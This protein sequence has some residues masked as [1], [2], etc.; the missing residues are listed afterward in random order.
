ML[1][2]ISAGIMWALET[3]ILGIALGRDFIVSSPESAALAPLVCTFF[4]DAFS[5][6]FLWIYVIVKGEVKNALK[7]FKMSDF[8]WL[9]VAS[10]VGGPIGM[11]GYV[12]A[13]NFMGA[14]VGAIASA[15]YPAIGSVLAFFFLKQ[16]LK[17]YQ[18][19]F[20]VLTLLGVFGI[21]YSP[22]IDISNFGM[23]LLGAFMCAF[24]W[25][26]EGVILSKCMQNDSVESDYALL[27]RQ[28][29]SGAV[30]GLVILP[31]FRG[32]GFTAQ[33]F[34]KGNISVLAVIALAAFC[35]TVS[36]LLYYKTIAK[37]G[38]AKAMALN[39]TYT[40]WATLFSVIILKDFRLLNPT[41]LGCGAVIVICGILSASDLS[42]LSK[43]KKENGR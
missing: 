33:F 10:A 13:V 17:G 18:W 43:T 20:L 4:H 41:T 5:A 23:G 12:T 34:E 19:F 26:T 25:G 15:V 14:S 8:K 35:A 24:G 6:I 36:Y 16:K 32:L 21:S 40:A 39:I 9:L 30:Y 28:T 1:T 38:V 22:N 3:V 29:T 11:T 27:I 7:V 2:G 37:K 42:F 31:L